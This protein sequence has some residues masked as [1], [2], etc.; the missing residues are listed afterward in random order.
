MALGGNIEYT[1][2]NV[3]ETITDEKS[4]KKA[5]QEH[6]ALNE[7]IL[8]KDLER[9]QK[10]AANLARALNEAFGKQIIDVGK[11]LKMPGADAFDDMTK[12]IKNA[13]VEG[14]FVGLKEGVNKSKSLLKD[15]NALNDAYGRKQ[16]QGWCDVGGDPGD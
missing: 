12:A 7:A 13:A 1:I 6:D 4:R 5:L 11:M 9:Q 14:M 15:I 10:S 2:K 3:I 16:Q 8:K